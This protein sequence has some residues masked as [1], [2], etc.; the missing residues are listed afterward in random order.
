MSSLLK[1]NVKKI[2]EEKNMTQIQLCVKALLCPATINRIETY[3]FQPRLATEKKI[4]RAL[5]V[6]VWEA[7]PDKLT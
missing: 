2:R 4:A 5:G 3:H 1:N 7:F 6:S